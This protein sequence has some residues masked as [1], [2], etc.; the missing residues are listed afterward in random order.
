MPHPSTGH[1]FA[2]KTGRKV[3][4]RSSPKYQLPILQPN[5]DSSLVHNAGKY[6]H[7]SAYIYIYIYISI[8]FHGH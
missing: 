3:C 6:N 7:S 5:T 8:S 1:V 4:P 2:K